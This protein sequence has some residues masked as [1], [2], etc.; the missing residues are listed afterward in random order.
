M[1]KSLTYFYSQNAM[2]TQM[3][4]APEQRSCNTRDIVKETPIC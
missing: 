1:V 4:V 2:L 3:L